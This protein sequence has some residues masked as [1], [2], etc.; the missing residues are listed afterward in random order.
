MLELYPSQSNY[1]YCMKKPDNNCL[2]TM[3]LEEAVRKK[4]GTVSVRSVRSIINYYCL[5]CK[6]DHFLFANKCYS[7][8]DACKNKSHPYSYDRAD[9]YVG[10][11]PKPRFYEEN[12]ALYSESGT[13]IACIEDF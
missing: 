4:D 12:C 2:E 5:K 9:D 3:A 11:L 7:K 10:C 8:K 6:E 1:S 13:C